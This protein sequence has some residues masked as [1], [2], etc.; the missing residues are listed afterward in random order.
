M[1]FPFVRHRCRVASSPTVHEA[2]LHAQIHKCEPTKH[3]QSR[4]LNLLLCFLH[5]CRAVR[6][7]VLP[8]TAAHILNPVGL[9]VLLAIHTCG[10]IAACQRHHGTGTSNSRQFAAL[11]YVVLSPKARTELLCHNSQ[12]LIAITIFTFGLPILR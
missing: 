5:I 7:A 1:L 3:F 4:K 12:V 9:N 10:L 2:A 6:D 11:C 8:L